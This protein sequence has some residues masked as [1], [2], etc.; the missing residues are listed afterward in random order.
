MS[1]ARTLWLRAFTALV[2]AALVSAALALQLH[3]VDVGQGDAVLIVEPGGRAVVYDAGRAAETMRDYLRHVGIDEVALVIASHGHADHIGGLPAVID[4]YQPAFVLDN[5]VPHTTRSFERYLEALERSG[6]QL[7]APERRTIGLGDVRLHVLPSPGRPAWGHNDN[8][9][10][11]LIEYGD[12]RASLT[13]DAE[14]RLFDWWLET[15]PELFV[16]VQLHKASHHGS[17][18]G[19]TSLALERLRPELVVVS[20]GSDNRYG[21]PHDGALARY[22]TVGATVF[23]TDLHGTVLVAADADGSYRVTTERSVPD[24]PPDAVPTTE[25]G[26]C[27]DLNAADL[28]TLQTIVHIGAERAEALVQRR[29]LGSVEDLSQVD[30]IGPARLRDI[31][32]QGLACIR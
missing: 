28:E 6:A 14:A 21:H 26:D 25:A 1:W 15:V 16:P 27:V 2:G 32:E 22:V 18:N 7:L 29:P 20:V 23:R 30:G 10:G 13:G 8:S 31:F 11:L 17:D 12:F 5:G 9:V 4:A 24:S 3:F 19:D